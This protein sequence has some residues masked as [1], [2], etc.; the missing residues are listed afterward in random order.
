MTPPRRDFLPA[1]LRLELEQNEFQGCVAVQA[2]QAGDQE[3]DSASLDGEDPE[4]G[5]VPQCF[6]QIVGLVTEADWNHRRPDDVAPYLDVAFEA[7]GPE[8][9][10]IGSDWPVCTGAA[11]YGRAM[12]AVMHDLGH[13]STAAQ[14]A[15]L[16]GNAQ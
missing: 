11:S 12:G 15:V 3:Q 9:L 6:S 14:E 16:G 4:A 2:R 7:F 5:G 13:L 10:M 8:R 1:E